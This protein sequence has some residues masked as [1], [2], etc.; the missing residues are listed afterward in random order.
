MLGEF[1]SRHRIRALETSPNSNLFLF[2]TR[3]AGMGAFFQ[4]QK[5]SPAKL[6]AF[7]YAVE[8]TFAVFRA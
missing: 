6:L 3:R 7:A 8:A 2:E 1:C 5:D 4:A